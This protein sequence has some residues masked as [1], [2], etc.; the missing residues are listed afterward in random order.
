MKEI[1]QQKFFKKETSI[2]FFVAKK[3]GKTFNI[4]RKLTFK[5]AY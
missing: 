5:H 4:L 1:L 3:E 2:L